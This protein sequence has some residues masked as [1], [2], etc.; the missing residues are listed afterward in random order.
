MVS[1][2]SQWSGRAASSRCPAQAARGILPGIVLLL[3]LIGDCRSA[4][5]DDLS[6][7]DESIYT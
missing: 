5:F 3:F 6:F 7:D 2:L 1:G 4:D